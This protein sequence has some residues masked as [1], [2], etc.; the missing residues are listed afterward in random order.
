MKILFLDIDGVLNSIDNLYV[1]NELS[2]IKGNFAILN[3]LYG[4]LF[5]ERCVRWLEYIILKTDCKIVISSTWKYLGLITLKKM[6]KFR[7]LPGEIIDCTSNEVS[8]E[9]LEQYKPKYNIE[10]RG[11]EI[12]QWIEIHKPTQYCIV[13]D[14]SDM[15]E[16]QNFV[17][18][19]YKYGLTEE[20]SKEIIMILN[21]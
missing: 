9:L 1:L 8:S 18:T 12:Q 19:N 7:K 20:K 13:D 10:D 2:T 16:H 5:D 14:N 11:Y 15:L 6:W 17:Q 3:D 21:S 4:Q